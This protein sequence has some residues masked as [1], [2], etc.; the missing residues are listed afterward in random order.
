MLVYGWGAGG[1]DGNW[2]LAVTPKLQCISWIG[3]TEVRP[4]PTSHAANCSSGT[5][6]E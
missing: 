1:W 5:S 6:S 4:N 3:Y 2:L